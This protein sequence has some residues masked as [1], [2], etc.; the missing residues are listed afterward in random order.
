VQ[1]A[2][3]PEGVTLPETLADVLLYANGILIDP[4]VEGLG[5]DGYLGPGRSD[6]GWLRIDDI[7]LLSAPE[8]EAPEGPEG[9]A[10]EDDGP[11]APEPATPDDVG[12]P[13]FEVETPDV[14][15]R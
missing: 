2:A 6:I 14:P 10:P 11:G 15:Q 1:S 4:I 13:D 8:S 5:E 7:E 12:T 3:L 9:N